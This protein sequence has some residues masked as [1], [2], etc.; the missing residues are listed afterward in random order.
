VAVLNVEQPG[1]QWFE[2]ALAYARQARLV[3]DISLAGVVEF[4]RRGV[5]AWHTP[6][7][8]APALAAPGEPSP[9][10]ARPIDL[11][12]FGFG[13][14]RREAFV[15]RH[16]G[17]F[18]GL[19]TAIL[20]TDARHPALASTPG[21]RSGADR[22]ALVA[23]SRIVLG[24]R[25]GDRDYFEQHRALLAL[26]NGALFVSEASR[27]AAPL[28]AGRHFV[29][30]PLDEL[31][32]LCRR[33]LDRPAEMDRIA[34]EGRAFVRTAMPAA[35][36]ARA[37]LAAARPTSGG[38]PAPSESERRAALRAR[39]AEA[40]RR[41]ERGTPPW[42]TSQN[43][44]YD[45]SPVPALSVVVT[46]YNYERFVRR[47][48]ESVAA[49]GR[50]AAGV[51]LVVVDD[52]ST[53]GSLAA[54]EGFMAATPLA[55]RIVR[56][57]LNT[58]L[59][60]ARNTGF[61][62]ARGRYVFVLDADNW[63]YPDCLTALHEAIDGSGH[64]GVY[65]LIARIDEDSG[66]GTGL[67][68]SRAWDPR[69]LLEGPYLDAMALLDR[70][71]VLSLGGYST[72]LLEHGFGWE[73]Y[74]LWLAL[75][76]AGH[77]CRLVPRLVAAYRDHRHSMLRQTNRRS[78]DL[79]RH[80][81]AKYADLIARYPPQ[82][83]YFAFPADDAPLTPELREIRDLKAHLTKLERQLAD[84]YRSASWRITAPLRAVLRAARRE[85]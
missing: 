63:V 70:R 76:R 4:E 15:A 19:R 47:C 52:A 6:L 11:L 13:S 17:L 30:A 25:A 8:F 77:T 43:A 73:D 65:G 60:D 46:V 31:P 64:A 58:G 32:S 54:V 69:A 57:Q 36:S 9:P 38:A 16:A 84:V 21:Y 66:D 71:L 62:C 68:S 78:G 5:P 79:A 40:A 51:E 29:S 48:L 26:A 74:D 56:K 28:E 81:R 34:G 35:R 10:S 72:D 53:D 14:E 37:M 23:S 80:F 3:Y 49:A 67:L 24:V 55:M 2:T 18:S 27:H 7:G 12:F 83:T 41:R 85:G 59:S 44:A 1:S 75:A 22:L 33:Y 42:T 45:A 82:D 50:P 61:A 39:I 20:L